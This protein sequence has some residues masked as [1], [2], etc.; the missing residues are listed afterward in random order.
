MKIVNFSLSGSDNFPDGINGIFVVNEN[1]KSFISFDNSFFVNQNVQFK[2]NGESHIFFLKNLIESLMQK[3]NLNSKFKS[4]T[5]DNE[6]HSLE[7]SVSENIFYSSAS[8]SE[9]FQDN[10]EI[11]LQDIDGNLIKEDISKF[12]FF[13]KQHETLVNGQAASF[14]F[15][16]KMINNSI[17]DIVEEIIKVN[18]NVKTYY[19]N[20]ISHRI[21]LLA[22]KKA[23]AIFNN[24][25]STKNFYFD[26]HG[27][28]SEK[29]NSFFIF[30]LPVELL[31]NFKPST[32][33]LRIDSGQKYTSY[34]LNTFD[35]FKSLAII[36]SSF[37]IPK[38]RNKHNNIVFY[39]KKNI[40]EEI[41]VKGLDY[42][43]LCNVIA[44]K[45][46]SINNFPNF[47]TRINLK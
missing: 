34:D 10:Q 29:S 36:F 12:K 46:H 25:K 30:R 2:G 42:Q 24:K 32:V 26:V 20:S 14:C 33:N 43:A 27:N 19:R 31:I 11:V 17:D 37:D 44:K 28:V 18:K 13:K 15:E 35:I 16:N 41:S 22:I 6:T 4:I 39:S 47:I 9:R 5:I 3:N 8:F 23:K 45:Y 1:T 7:N 40:I 21:I 38:E